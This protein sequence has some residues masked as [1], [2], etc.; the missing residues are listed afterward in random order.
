MIP[1][2]TDPP[3][4][5][6]HRLSGEPGPVPGCPVFDPQAASPWWDRERRH[7]FPRLIDVR[8]CG[9]AVVVAL[10][11]WALAGCGQQG[12]V[13]SAGDRPGIVGRV[14][15]GPQCPVEQA[16]HPCPDKPAAGATITVTKQ[17]SHGASAPVVA[18][19]TTDAHGDFRVALPRGTY[20]VTAH[21]GMSCELVRTRVTGGSDSKVDIECDTGIR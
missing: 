17:R 10:V 7:G 1:E 21:T 13:G 11:V 8:A 18:R 15:L 16:E 5:A 20:V 14:R 19:T 9:S 2:A 4:A 3:G 6:A 12:S